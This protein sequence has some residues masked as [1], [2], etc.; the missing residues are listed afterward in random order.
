MTNKLSCP[1]CEAVRDIELIERE[2]TVE[3]KGRKITFKAKLSRCATCGETFEIPGQ[4]DANLLEARE[5]YARL[6][7]SPTSEQI[8]SIRS[9]YGAS[10][11]A[12]GLILGFGEL[13]IN[14]YEQGSVPEPPNRLLLKL[15][16]NPVIFKA[17]F[18]IN[19]TRIG[20]TQRN[21]LESSE[22]FQAAVSWKAMDALYTELTPLE[23]TRIETCAARFNH[24]VLQHMSAYI[25][26]ASFSDYSK[27][28]LDAKWPD[29][30]AR[31]LPGRIA[32]SDDMLWQAA[33]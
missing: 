25:R 17:M 7:E 28:A 32:I 9:R 8:V 33:S 23:R 3:I 27:L 24:S 12:F 26:E 21:R 4:L 11:K 5:A 18:D 16:E 6:Y 29:G 14:S 31:S 15:A 13:T 10:Q 20:A 30:K 22:G 19:K 2:E 1:N